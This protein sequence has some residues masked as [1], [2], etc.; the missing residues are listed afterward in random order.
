MR[1]VAAAW[2]GAACCGCCRPARFSVLLRRPRLQKVVRQ[3]QITSE[4]DSSSR[5][6]PAEPYL[7]PD[8]ADGGRGCRIEQR[9]HSAARVAFHYRNSGRKTISAMK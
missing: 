9:L 5:G 4:F 7:R 8:I 3:T 6:H 2:K 1:K